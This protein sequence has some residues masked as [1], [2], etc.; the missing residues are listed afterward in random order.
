MIS[1]TDHC[2]VSVIHVK[3]KLGEGTGQESGPLYASWQG[4]RAQSGLLRR[5]LSI[6][7]TPLTPWIRACQCLRSVS[8]THQKIVAIMETFK[9]F[10]ENLLQIG[11]KKW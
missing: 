6:S 3:P 10:D 4:A 2:P 5:P 1:D 9:M 8:M 7:M 11:T